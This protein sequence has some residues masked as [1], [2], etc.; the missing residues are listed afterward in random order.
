MF[1]R[2]VKYGFCNNSSS[3]HSI[4][5]LH[6]G[7]DPE[8]VAPEGSYF[9]WDHF[10]L[11]SRQDKVR[12]LAGLFWASLT[13]DADG[14]PARWGFHPDGQPHDAPWPRAMEDAVAA[15][16]FKRLAD[17]VSAED[18]AS[19]R[20]PQEEDRPWEPPSIDHQSQ[21]VLPLYVAGADARAVL[22]VLADELLRED[23][24]VLGGNDNEDDR[25]NLAPFRSQEAPL[26]LPWQYDRGN[27]G[28]ETSRELRVRKEAW[29]FSIFNAEDGSRVHL[30]TG[31]DAPVKNTVPDLVDVKITD[32]CGFGCVYCYQGSTRDGKHAD[33]AYLKQLAKAL[34]EQRAWEVALGGGEP[35]DHPE[36]AHILGTFMDAGLVVNFTTR[37]TRWL[38]GAELLPLFLEAEPAR[39]RMGGVAFSV[40]T[41]EDVARFEAALE[42]S[43]LAPFIAESE[44]APGLQVAYQYVPGTGDA[45]K[46]N[47]VVKAVREANRGSY[48]RLTLL[49]FKTAGRG[50]AFR[51][52]HAGLSAADALNQVAI[53]GLW[54]VGVDTA[55]VREPGAEEALK[56]LGVKA[57]TYFKTEGAHSCY[58]D[59]VAQTLAASSYS[60]KPGLFLPDPT[61]KAFAATFAR[62]G[63]E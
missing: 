40:D 4:V 24:A 59:A 39:G 51:Q 30:A 60:A 23:V 32:H 48:R 41:A 9:G 34:K 5:I 2:N 37:A 29:G 53:N 45:E 43:W 3:T 42:A 50:G 46:L 13:L 61:P 1:T 47:G 16:F 21:P 22:K 49:G 26:F 57:H 58:V 52:V 6:P 7:Q 54:A 10:L 44:S 17:F 8:A 31:P 15:V 18:I 38:R 36:F 27:R 56:R 63:E 11:R 33:V 12:Y 62:I 28:H 14:A 55:F 25:P 19:L 35:T 20:V